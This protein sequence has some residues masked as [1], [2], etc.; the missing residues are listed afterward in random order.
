MEE[1][2]N[3]I[4]ESDKKPRILIVDDNP[5]NLQVL[6]RLLLEKSFEIEFATSGKA[7]LEWLEFQQFDLVLLDINMP[8]MGGLGVL[9]GLKEL[10]H[11]PLVYMLTGD[12]DLDT[13]VKALGLG[14]HGYITKPFDVK[15]LRD[16]VIS[17]L[18]ER[19]KDKTV[20][21]KPWQVKKKK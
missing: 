16:V 13:A 20:S 14:A 15:Q 12:Q 11:K 10:S 17:A 8:S 6:G 7:A 3:L 5:Q 1:I 9:A 19:D 2:A 4:M 21:D 18:D